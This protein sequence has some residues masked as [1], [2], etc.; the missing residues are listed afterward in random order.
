MNPPAIGPGWLLCSLQHVRVH[1]EM[2]VVAC[3]K[4]IWEEGLMLSSPSDARP[5]APK[6]LILGL[7]LN[8]RL[9]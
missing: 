2:L 8:P 4:V 5:D 7:S 9:S 6:P 3:T 1:S